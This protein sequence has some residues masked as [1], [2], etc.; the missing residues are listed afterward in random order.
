MGPSFQIGWDQSH[1]AQFHHACPKGP[2]RVMEL[3]GL[4]KIGQPPQRRT[5]PSD[6]KGGPSLERPQTYSALTRARTCPSDSCNSCAPSPTVWTYPSDG[7]GSGLTRPT[8]LTVLLYKARVPRFKSDSGTGPNPAQ[9]HHAR[10]QGPKL[11]MELCGLP[12]LA[13]PP[14]SGPVRLQRGPTC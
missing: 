8:A 10:P 1:P 6:C 14:A 11:V 13:N 9:F 3:C 2:K 4:P 5:Y 7:K 12:Q